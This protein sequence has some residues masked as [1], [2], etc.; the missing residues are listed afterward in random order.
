MGLDNF[1]RR[2][3]SRDVEAADFDENEL[4]DLNGAKK[5]KH[6]GNGYSE[7]GRGPTNDS[8]FSLGADSDDDDEAG[9]SDAGRRKEASR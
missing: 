7:K 4:D 9:S 2:D 8:S 6:P 5:K 3:R 1:R